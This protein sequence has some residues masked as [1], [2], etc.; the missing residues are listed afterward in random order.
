MQ[1]VSLS[2]KRF[3]RT[4][5]AL[6]GFLVTFSFLPLSLAAKTVAPLQI[7][8]PGHGKTCSPI[9]SSEIRSYVYSDNLDSFDVTIS[10]FRYVA[11]SASVGGSLIPFRYAT[12]WLEQ[13]GG[14][15]THFD[16]PPTPLKKN[17]PI[18]VTFL[19]VQ[20]D[21]TGA[22]VTCLYSIS[23]IVSGSGAS[24][25]EEGSAQY[26][27]GSSGGNSQSSGNSGQ[28]PEEGSASSTEG[29]QNAGIVGATSALG[30]LCAHGG[31]SRLW[32]VLLVLYVVFV[33]L[34]CIQKKEAGPAIKEWNIVLILAVFL[35]LLVFWYMS[36]M[37]RAGFWTPILATLIAVGGLLY[38]AFQDVGPQEFLLLKDAE[39]IAKK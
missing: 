16:V 6:A 11:V 35:G 14:I 2:K 3:A 26:P 15:K 10:D 27:S 33:V 4:K 36:A 29:V 38:T 8:P 30:A 25:S 22:S 37:C 9:T 31:G 7:I 24:I 21:A 13:G 1:S 5:I 32:F 23:G 18:E 20:Q 19:S 39:K 12:R 28:L 17:I 34:L